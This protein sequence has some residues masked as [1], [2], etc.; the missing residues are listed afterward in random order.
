MSLKTNPFNEQQ[1]TTLN[2]LLPGLTKEQI[3]WLSGYLEG[4]LAVEGGVAVSPQPAAVVLPESSTKLTILYGT[5]TGHSHGLAEKLAQ[6]A[7]NKNIN[8]QVLSMYDFNYKKLKE[9]ENVAII[10]STHG[11]GEPPDMAEDFYKFVTG[12]RAPQLEK[13]NYSVLA[14]GDKTYKHFC[15]TG[16]DIY[17]ALKALGAHSVCSLA[18][19]DVDYDRD[20]EI[21]MNNFLVSLLSAQPAEQASVSTVTSA[22]IVSEGS[23]LAFDE[24]S[25]SNPYMATVLEKVKITGRDSD[26]EVYHVELSLEGSGLE[27]EPGDSIGI[28][29]KNPEALVEQILEKTGF[30]PEQKVD[31]KEEEI[32]IKDALSHHLEITTLTFDVLKKYQEKVKNPDLAKIINDNKLSDDYLYGHDVLDLL[33]DF[34]FEWNAN[35]LAEV[36]RPI[37]PRLYSIS[38]SMESVGEEVHVTVSVVRYERKDRLRNGACSSHLADTIEIDDQL[39][40]YVD[41]NPSFK[42]PA[43]GS[44]IIMVG[45]GTGVAPYRAFMQHRESLGIKGESWLFFGDRRFSSDFLYQ[46]E[47]QKLLKSEHLS[48]LDV[49]FS[50]DQEEKVYVQHKLKENQKEVFE[51][52]ENGA[53]FYLCGDMKYM[54]KDVNK[55]LLEI[56]QTQGGVT[57]EQAEK[58]VKNLK[59]E[60]RFQTDVY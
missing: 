30:N 25:K 51:W 11:E 9:E 52:I 17:S 36:L 39:P 21:W 23:S 56:I 54:A 20:A 19:C 41:K 15:K 35:K 55:T 47:W 49:A 38:S 50:R 2:Q 26:K 5:E 3:L 27:Y 8:A 46:A 6:K 14:M 48:K 57:E 32:T 4:R 44:K 13:L 60:K 58:Y 42:L 37:P 1:L 43:N 59:R 16:E 40:I 22:G 31:V 10:V 18:K 7:T 28:F 33:E 24:F 45:A 34:P 53:H 12:T 29:A